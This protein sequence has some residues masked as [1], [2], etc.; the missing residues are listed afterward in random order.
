MCI[1]WEVNKLILCI[2]FAMSK[3]T[4]YRSGYITENWWWRNRNWSP[5]NYFRIVNSFK[6][7]FLWKKYMYWIY[8][9]RCSLTCIMCRAWSSQM[10]DLSS[11]NMHSTILSGCE[12]NELHHQWS[13]KGLAVYLEIV[14]HACYIF[15]R[16]FRVY[17]KPIG[18]VNFK[19]RAGKLT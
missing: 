2:F 8:T 6:I 15:H 11:L 14:F 9:R 16:M 1:T 7:Q 17:I 10:W 5:V 18:S 19:K 13:S 4:E 3:G 12:K